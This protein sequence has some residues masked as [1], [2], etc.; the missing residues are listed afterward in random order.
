MKNKKDEEDEVVFDWER[1]TPA[2]NFPLSKEEPMS[3]KEIKEHWLSEMQKMQQELGALKSIPNS[4]TRIQK[5]E[6]DLRIASAIY[7]WATHD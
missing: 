5:L 2:P 6:E 7:Y 3:N 1:T 4:E